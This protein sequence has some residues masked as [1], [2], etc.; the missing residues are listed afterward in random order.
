MSTEIINWLTGPMPERVAMFLQRPAIDTKAEFAARQIL[1]EIRTGGV[2]A[3][4]RCIERYDHVHLTAEQ[5]QVRSEELAGLQVDEQFR[6]AAV[7]AQQ[8]IKAFAEAGIRR[9]WKLPTAHGG[10]V[11]EQFV[12]FERVGI[13]VPGGSAPLVSTVL[14]TVTLAAAAHV[15]E[16]VVCTPA[17]Q[18][19][20][21][22]PYLLY[23]AQLCGA[24]EIYKIGGAHAIAAMAYGAGPLQKVQ[25]IV[26]PGGPYVTAAK[27]LVYGTVAL[28]MI[29][30]PSEV[31]VLA[32]A[33]ANPAWV[34]ADML[35]QAEHGTGAEKSL[36]VTTSRDVAQQVQAELTRQTEKLSR[37]ALIRRVLDQ[38]TLIV[39]VADLAQGMALCNDFAPEHLELLVAEPEIWAPQVKAAG[40]VFLGPW[41]PE[42]AGDFV[43]GPSHVLPTGGAARLFSGLTVD[44]F[45]RRTSLISYTQADLAEVLPAI[46]MFGQVEGLDAHA[47]SARV[48]L[49]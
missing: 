38:G 9:D 24:T 5:L 28:D 43:A 34:A 30:G 18:D 17:G 16:I 14:M 47:E 46:E 1:E 23:A 42:S 4:L 37:A 40:A 3:L 33:E 22:N 25:K 27:R 31:A 35:A 10:Y 15:P 13:Y 8:R 20:R 7:L 32:D 21:I 6:A 19:G 39:V 36:L 29:A 49:A 44:D 26:G 45:R 12:P 48:R 11:G 41:S 2:D